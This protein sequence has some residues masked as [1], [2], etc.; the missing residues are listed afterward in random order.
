MIVATAWRVG[1]HSN[2]SENGYN[3]TTWDALGYY[4]YLPS[5]FIYQDFENLDWFE[6]VDKKYELSGGELY[7]ASLQEDSSYVFKYLG[8]TA[9]MQSPFFLIGHLAAN[10]SDAPAD[11]FSA[12][13]QYA[14]IW[15]ALFWF[16]IGMVFLRKV[17]LEFYSDKITMIAL[18]LIAL[19][20]NLLQYVSIDGAMS[21]VYIFPLYS[22]LLWLTIQW[23]KSP[24]SILSLKIGFLIGL[25]TICRP[26]EFIMIFIPILWVI[27]KGSLKSIWQYIFDHRRYVLMA[28][29]GGIVGIFPQLLYWK[30]ASGNWIYSVGSKWYFLN[31][32]WRVLIGFEKG[33]FIYTP[34]SILM[35]AGFF[36]IKNKVFRVSVITFCLLNIWIIIS[37]SDW[38]YGATYSTRALTQS[39]PVFALALAGL[40]QYIDYKKWK[41]A[42][43]AVLLYLIGVNQ[44]QLWQYNA[45]I[46][47]YDDMNRRYYSAIYLDPSPTPLDYSYLD[48]G[49]KAPDVQWKPTQSAELKNFDLKQYEIRKLATQEITENAWI[50]FKATVNAEKGLHNGKWV[51]HYYMNGKPYYRH[52]FR[53]AT[54]QSENSTAVSYQHELHVTKGTDSVTVTL[55]AFNSMKINHLKAAIFYSEQ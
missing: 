5:F 31:P 39:Y 52:E 23:K 35:I 22:L 25:A 34:I 11:G 43:Y 14:I 20:T 19:A 45:G 27:P 13:Y 28:L 51:Y 32:W 47:H 36:F 18:L 29:L 48:S 40:I 41:W 9:M 50:Q 33:W 49:Q 12:P 46:V 37:W 2:N 4:M 26:T 38:R 15:G 21:H 7:Q 8:G 6:A 44:F 53:C 17:L 30:L 3:A 54:P 42:A 10:L 1:Y 24:S 55:R 16:M